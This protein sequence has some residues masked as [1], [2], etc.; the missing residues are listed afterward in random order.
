[1][2]R[3]SGVFHKKNLRRMTSRQNLADGR[4]KEW[5][6]EKM[7]QGR[8]EVSDLPPEDFLGSLFV[9]MQEGKSSIAC[10]IICRAWFSKGSWKSIVFGNTIKCWPAVSLLS[11][12]EAGP[13]G[14][15]V[16]DV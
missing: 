13:V 2:Q 15:A 5:I 7:Q 3:E 10:N 14:P 12:K 8:R 4:M 9:G 6:V 1:M 11:L 16:V